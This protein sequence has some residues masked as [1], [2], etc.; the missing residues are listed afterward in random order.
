M[1]PEHAAAGVEAWARVGCLHTAVLPSLS[2]P[3]VSRPQTEPSPRK[4]QTD[5]YSDHLERLA[6]SC[7]STGRQ[8][9]ST[10]G[11]IG[12]PAHCCPAWFLCLGAGR[13]I[14]VSQWQDW[15]DWRP[16][17]CCA[18]LAAGDGLRL[19]AQEEPF[20]CV[21]SAVLALGITS[22]VPCCLAGQPQEDHCL[23]SG[24]RGAGGVAPVPQPGAQLP[25]G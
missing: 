18:A 1:S 6:C 12:R 19:Q 11:L 23:H 2:C 5:S 21:L 4:P 7:S 13:V 17:G 14:Y 16:R 20:Y 25:S 9:L 10:R 22:C 24:T 8:V 15:A 3:F